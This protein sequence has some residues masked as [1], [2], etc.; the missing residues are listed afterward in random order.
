[1]SN[2]LPKL[3]ER[4]TSQGEDSSYVNMSFKG[5]LRISGFNEEIANF[6]DKIAYQVSSSDGYKVDLKLGK[7]K[8]EVNNLNVIGNITTKDIDLSNCKNLYLGTYTKMPNTKPTDSSVKQILVGKPVG[9]VREFSFQTVN[10]LLKEIYSDIMLEINQIPTG[11][12]VFANITRDEFD[13][14]SDLKDDYLPCDGRK[15]PVAEFPEL[16]KILN[17]KR[18]DVYWECANNINE[19]KEVE[20]DFF[21]GETASDVDYF[22]VPDWRAMFVQSC[23][24]NPNEDN[25]AKITGGYELDAIP[26]LNSP[27]RIDDHYHYIILDNK[28]NDKDRLNVNVKII[29][30]AKAVKDTKNYD[31]PIT[32]T[33]KPGAI[34]RYGSFA[35]VD[36]FKHAKRH[37]NRCYKWPEFNYYYAGGQGRTPIY[38]RSKELCGCRTPSLPIGPTCG[39]I[40]SS[41]KSYNGDYSSSIKLE[42]YIGLSSYNIPLEATGVIDESVKIYGESNVVYDQIEDTNSYPSIKPEIIGYENTPEFYTCLPLIKI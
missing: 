6:N 19:R 25:S 33:E 12:I 35:T 30:F 2:L 27:Q 37:Q 8:F 31:Y 16:A 21:Y 41:P 20:R 28:P 18:L 26:D 10:T 15:Y 11:T 39:Y 22:R 7:N 13:K 42:N 38:T 29:K 24:L 5:I 9:G 23:S 36:L 14:Q 1:M 32:A 17:D 34:T 3:I 4:A 40:L